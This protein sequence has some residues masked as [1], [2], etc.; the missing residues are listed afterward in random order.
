[1]L[2]SPGHFS[3]DVSTRLSWS[4]PKYTFKLPHLHGLRTG[5][6][7]YNEDQLY[8]VMQMLCNFTCRRV[9]TGDRYVFYFGI[10]L[11]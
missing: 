10:Y 2:V 9:V 5:S 8:A 3:G 1:M 11:K 6:L 7:I 4:R